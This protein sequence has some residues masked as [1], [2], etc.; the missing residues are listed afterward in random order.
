MAHFSLLM[1][2]E[3]QDE[4]FA[5][6]DRG[7]V[8]VKGHSVPLRCFILSRNLRKLPKV[9]MLLETDLA[10]RSPSPSSPGENPTGKLL[11]F[12]RSATQTPDYFLYGCILGV[13]QITA[14]YQIYR[15]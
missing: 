13:L 14:L 15:A 12:C 10:P 2:R 8:M 9:Q 4:Q 3:C 7:A 11:F 5:F 6:K 1:S